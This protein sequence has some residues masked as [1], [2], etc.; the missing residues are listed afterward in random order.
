MASAD[1]TAPE[2]VPP[3]PAPEDPD[4][5]SPDTAAAA[6]ASTPAPAPAPAPPGPGGAGNVATAE[7]GG[8]AGTPGATRPLKLPGSVQLGFAVTAQQG[9]QPMSGAFGELVWLQNG[10][11]YN[12]R[13]SIK[14]LFKTVRAQT[15]VGRIGPLGIDPTR[16]SDTRRTEVASHFVRESGEIV[17]SNNAPRAKLQPGAQDRLSVIM[18][19]SAL[20]A[21]DPARYPPGSQ[22]SMQT[23]GERDAEVWTFTVDGEDAVSTPA[24]DF[25]AVRLTRLPRRDYDYKLELWLAPE[26]NWLPVRIRQTQQNGDFIDLALRSVEKPREPS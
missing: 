13:L 15:S 16:F 26:Q 10:D 20:I 11:E 21:G 24:G 4:P 1:S 8:G 23:V 9:P 17:F 3:P 19:I 14:M 22:L 2:T 18:Q 6:P 5:A 12:A 7:A 25:R